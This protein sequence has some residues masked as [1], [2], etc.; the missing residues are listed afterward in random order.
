MVIIVAEHTVLE[1]KLEVA[2]KRVAANTA[3]VRRQPGF[4]F[5]YTTIDRDD[6]L[7]ITTLTAMDDIR[8]WEAWLAMRPSIIGSAF[9]GERPYSIRSNI[10]EV[11]EHVAP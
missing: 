1:G 6:P 7:K 4:V 11:T 9:P 8:S 3:A 5:R 2:E 10:Y